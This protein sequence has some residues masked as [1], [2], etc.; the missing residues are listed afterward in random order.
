M[1]NNEQPAQPIDPA[2]DWRIGTSRQLP[3]ALT[4]HCISCQNWVHTTRTKGTCAAIPLA[5]NNALITVPAGEVVTDAV[6]GCNL[7]A[8]IAPALFID[9]A[10]GETPT[11]FSRE[12]TALMA[13][14]DL[15][16]SLGLMPAA[17]D[18]FTGGGAAIERE[19]LRR[20]ERRTVT[21]MPVEP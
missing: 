9:P 5:K 6:F 19:R 2:D 18:D 14:T 3:R 13:R 16:L 10:P 17:P 4:G 1:S 21:L 20:E 15:A 8:E 12:E 7:H 11:A